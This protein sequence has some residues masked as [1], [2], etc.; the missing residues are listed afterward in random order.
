M[1]P[2][3]E[4]PAIPP[5]SRRRCPWESPAWQWLTS[6]RAA[7]AEGRPLLVLVVGLRLVLVR[8]G[9]LLLH[10]PHV[11]M[12]LHPRVELLLLLVW[13]TKL[14]LL[15]ATCI[16]ACCTILALPLPFDATM[17]G[18]T[19]R[20][21]HAHTYTRV[22]HY[23]M[24]PDLTGCWARPAEPRALATCAC[25]NTPHAALTARVSLLS[26]LLAQTEQHASYSSDAHLCQQPSTPAHHPCLPRRRLHQLLRR[27]CPAACRGL[28]P[29][30]L[31]EPA[32]LAPSALQAARAGLGCAH[33]QHNRG[34]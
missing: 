29:G 30:P 14:L 23:L 3:P 27:A 15:A 1:P 21:A 6:T 31:E 7:P 32:G 5:A 20:V 28:Q 18:Q 16:V 2:A 33:L 26:M 11:V 8:R 4:A 12:L 34:W 10:R 19:C 25:C 24:M 17:H 9:L 13:R 22:R